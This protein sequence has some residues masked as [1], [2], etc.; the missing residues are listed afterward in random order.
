MSEGASDVDLS[1]APWEED[2]DEYDEEDEYDMDI[3]VDAANAR[4]A[5]KSM[6]DKPGR[7]IRV[8]V[9]RSRTVAATD[10]NA[11]LQST[12]AAKEAAGKKEAES[13]GEEKPKIRVVS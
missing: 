10:P 12:L 2:E 11:F 7:D 1:D 9:E 6:G 3:R 4:P 8:D 13:P 5:R